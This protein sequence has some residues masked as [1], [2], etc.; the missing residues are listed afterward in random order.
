MGVGGWDRLGTECWGRWGTR[1][2]GGV[3]GDTGGVTGDTGGV[4]GGVTGEGAW[5]PGGGARD[6]GGVTRDPG[7]EAWDTGG[8]A[9][10]AGRVTGVRL[11]VPLQE[12]GAELQG[13]LGGAPG[14]L[15]DTVQPSG[16]IG[17][18]R[19]VVKRPPELCR[20]GRQ[21]GGEQRVAPNRGHG[22]IQ[23]PVG[24]G[25]EDECHLAPSDRNREGL[26]SDEIMAFPQET[27][28]LAEVPRVTLGRWQARFPPGVQGLPLGGHWRW[29]SRKILWGG[30]VGLRRRSLHFLS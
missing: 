19:G 4:T 24:Q 3:T 1:G 30:R 13:V 17:P 5:D 9:W 14:S 28:T 23:S 25:G 8:G 27:P 26:A 18:V 7:A 21:I 22:P 11:L 10:R 29:G 12:H 6:T 20:E 15:R 2:T 16:C